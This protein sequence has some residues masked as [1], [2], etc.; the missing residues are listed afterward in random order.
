MESCGRRRHRYS[1]LEIR[2]CRC[3]WGSEEQEQEQ[4]GMCRADSGTGCM[5]TCWMYYHSEEVD[6]R[7]L[8]GPV[9]S[10]LLQRSQARH[11]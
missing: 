5:E 2:T 7:G 3:R 10:E 11:G 9:E 8:E 4:G 6:H 1:A